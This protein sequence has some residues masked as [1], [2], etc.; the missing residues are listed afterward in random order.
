MISK[1][2]FF[3]TTV[4][5]AAFSACKQTDSSSN[6]VT[7]MSNLSP[8]QQKLADIDNQIKMLKKKQEVYKARL[9]EATDDAMRTEFDDDWETYQGN[10]GKQEFIQDRVN[11]IT[12]QIQQLEKQ[13]KMM[14][15]KTV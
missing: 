8:Q 3:I 15:G 6:E 10:L 2:I 12:A 4:A 11:K 7:I 5:I 1:N 14:Q 9:Y 13:K